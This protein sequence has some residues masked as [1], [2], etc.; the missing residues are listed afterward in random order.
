LDLRERR[1][2]GDEKIYAVRSFKIWV[3]FTKNMMVVNQRHARLTE[4]VTRAEK[5]RNVLNI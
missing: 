2:H 5:V 3:L 4:H 1:Q